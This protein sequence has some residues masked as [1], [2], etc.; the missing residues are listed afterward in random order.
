[1]IAMIPKVAFFALHTLPFGE[2]RRTGRW[3]GEGD[4]DG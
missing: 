3:F 1:M 2:F 4:A